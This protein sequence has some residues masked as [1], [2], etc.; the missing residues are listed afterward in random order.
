MLDNPDLLNG[1]RGGMRLVLQDM[2]MGRL[3][4]GQD[5]L[6]VLLNANND[7]D[8]DDPDEFD[9]D[10]EGW[11]WRNGQRAPISRGQPL[12][13]RRPLLQLFLLSLLPWITLT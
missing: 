9:G 1:E 6:D 10:G 2:G 13:L 5:I 7:Q 12:D 3:A 8:A 11:R 4:A